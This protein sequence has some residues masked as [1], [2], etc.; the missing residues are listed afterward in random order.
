MLR[1]RLQDEITTIEMCHGKVNAIDIEFSEAL[2]DAIAWAEESETRCLVLRSVTSNRVFSA[3]IDLKRIISE[4]ISYTRD[5]LPSLIRLF[6][7]IYFCSKPIL[8]VVEGVAIAGG[9]VISA[10]CNRRI[11]TPWAK[12][13]MPNKKLDVPIPQLAPIIL[14]EAVPGPES[15]ELHSEQLFSSQQALE[16]GLLDEIVWEEQLLASRIANH[17]NELIA[18]AFVSRARD[19][20]QLRSL[21]PLDQQMIDTWC[22]PELRAR[23]SKYIA[24]F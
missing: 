2:I 18:S 9:C 5:Y 16:C 15:K 23:I 7:R 13:G 19:E 8:A 22:S 6:E 24:S 14:R 4:P 20:A 10:A 21:E 17:T 1:F 3:G 12:F 11:G